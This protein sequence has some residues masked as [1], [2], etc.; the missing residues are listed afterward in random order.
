[1]KTFY[2]NWDWRV[3]GR[4]PEGGDGDSRLR[5]KH[6]SAAREAGDAQTN[7]R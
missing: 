7:L 2:P 5:A 6:E 1:M 3:S 4:S